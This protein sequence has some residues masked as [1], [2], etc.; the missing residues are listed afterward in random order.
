MRLFW[1]I[2]GLIGIILTGIS[3]GEFFIGFHDHD[4]F[5]LCLCIMS[6]SI[7]KALVH[8]TAEARKQLGEDDE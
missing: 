2:I 6:F 8:A 1:A 3:V 7:G 4:A 5:A